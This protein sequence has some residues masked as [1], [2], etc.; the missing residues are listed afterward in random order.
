VLSEVIVFIFCLNLIFLKIPK[1]LFIFGS[2]QNLC[3]SW[4]IS[5]GKWVGGHFVCNAIM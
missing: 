2:E 4:L 5:C 1:K 3:S